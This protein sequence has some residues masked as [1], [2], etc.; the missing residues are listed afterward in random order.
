MKP[1]EG[2][3][4]R[5]PRCPECELALICGACPL[6][7]WGEREPAA[8]PPLEEL[9]D[10]LAPALWEADEWWHENVEKL[11]ETADWAECV[12]LHMMPKIIAVVRAESGVAAQPPRDESI[13]LRK[14]R[15][16][17]QRIADDDLCD[18][19]HDDK[20][21]CEKVWY[22]CPSC[23]AGVALAEETPG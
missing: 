10:K 9:A 21:C 7:G 23:I 1:V 8:Q 11:V 2:V 19:M 22:F 18:C 20:N 15:V 17:L 14:F 16:A 5:E 3:E 4:S 12:L 6:C 13:L